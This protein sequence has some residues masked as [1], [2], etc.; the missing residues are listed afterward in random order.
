LVVFI[1]ELDRCRP[2]YAVSILEQLK[3]LFSVPR[4]VFVLAIDKVQLGHAVRGVYGS[5]LIDADE[6]LRRFIDVEYSIPT[7][8]GSLFIDYL[9]TYF[10]FDSF[11]NKRTH[12]ELRYDYRDFRGI[13]KLLLGD[14]ALPLRLQEKIL[15]HC[16]IALDTLPENEYLF[17]DV[18]LALVYLKTSR[19]KFYEEL[20]QKRV[21][22]HELLQK[23]KTE[24]PV[25]NAKERSIV[26]LETRLLTLYYNGLNLRST[27]NLYEENE[28]KVSS[29]FSSAYLDGKSQGEFLHYLK[30]ALPNR[31]GNRIGIDHVTNKV[32]L[33]CNS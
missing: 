18:F 4:M 29:V 25:T 11:L 19:P 9:L 33:T 13:A 31:W 17:A 10:E 15:A 12:E 21:N 22:I 32:D 1:D 7:P 24:L 20:K 14:G 28:G 6:Y 2:D 27:I 3:H 5:D 30:H 23:F 16:R 26:S 8:E